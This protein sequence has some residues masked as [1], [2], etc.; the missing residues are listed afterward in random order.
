MR[1]ALLCLLLA[2]A[3]PGA[4]QEL[5]FI[6]FAPSGQA[7]RV[8]FGTD[9]LPGVPAPSASV[10][11]I[12][13]DH[14]GYIWMAFYSSGIARYDGRSM[15]TY[16]TKD[17]LTDPLVRE[18]VEDASHR[19]WVGTEAGLVVSEKPLDAYAPGER[20]K[21]VSK[22][23]NVALTRA[24]MRRNCVVASPDGSVW[25]SAPDGI[26]RYRFEG[27]ALRSD[28]VPDTV[29]AQAL[30]ARRDGTLLAGRVDGRIVAITPDKKQR[31]IGTV[32]SSAT[33]LAET[34]D[35]AIWGGSTD[36]SVWIL[37]NG[38]PR[39]INHE[40]GERVVA[41]HPTHDGKHVWAASLGTGAVRMDR[42]D[43]SDRM[44]ITRAN[45]LLGETLWTI[46]EDR[47]GNL[48]FGQNGGA[49]R[50]RKGYSAFYTWTENTVP[51]LPDARTFAVLPEWRGSMWIATG[52]GLAI[53]HGDTT[54]TLTVGDGLHSNQIYALAPDPEGRLWIATS[55]GINVLSNANH[56]PP[57][58]LAEP[59]R[60]PVIINGEPGVVS[61]LGLETTYAAQRFGDTMCFAGGWGAACWNG[62]RYLLFRAA[63]GLSNTGA[64]SVELD[65][66]GYLWIGSTDR[67]LFHST[68]TLQE[69]F[70]ETPAAGEVT[71][72]IFVAAWT[73]EE[74]APTNGIRSLLHHGDRLWVGTGAGLAALTTSKPFTATNVFAGQPVVGLTPSLDG[75]SIWVSNN[76]GLVQ[77]DARTLA[78]VSRVT[79]AD[80]LADD[81]AWAYGP[82]ATD[83]AGRIYLSTPSGVSVFNP[84]LRERITTPPL[85][86]LRNVLRDD[87]NEIALEYAALSFAD[88][89]RIR[90]RT[91]L[92]GFDKH[93]SAETSDAKTRYTNLPAYLF[94]RKYTF[95]VMARN[96]EG[97]WSQPLAYEFG[98]VPPLGLRWWAVL[99]Y[100]IAIVLALWLSNRWR[101]RQ[102]KRKNR[103]LEDLVMK[104]T[105]EIRA[106]TRE[107]ETL[108]R[109]VEVIN[110]EVVL[111]NVLKTIISQGMKLFPQ[112]QKAVFL[113]FDHETRRTEVINVSGYDPDPFNGSSLT[114]EE[115]MSRYSERAEQLE[116][117]V[118]LIKAA[119]FRHLAGAEK[120]AHLPAPKAMLA[121]ALTLGGRMEGFLIFDNFTDEDAFGRHDLQKLARVREHAV[122][123]IAK[124]R[125]LRELEIRNEQ[126]EEAN[127]AK[128]IFLA[129]MSH[130]LR[131]PMNA[132]IGFSEI[133][134]ERLEERLEPKYIG[135]LR[136]ILQSGQH[137]LSIIND[138]LDLSKVEAG[139]M[140][141][142]PETFG[143]RAGID[144]VCQV[145]K[146]MSTNKGITFD[147][148]VEDGVREIETD[149]AKFKQ[150]LYN[151]L[152]NAVK[153]SKKNGVVTIRARRVG[154]M[155]SVSVTDA[156]IGIAPEHLAVI[157]QEFRQIDTA[158]SRAYGGTGL[159]LSLVKKFVELLRGTVTVTSV[160]D[161]GSTFTFMLPLRFAGAAI[162]SPIVS[163]DGVVIPPGER[164]L[165][166]EDEDA[167]FDT[168]SA[169]LQSAG[170]VPV[171]ARTGQEALERA[172]VMSPRAITLD[173]VLPG[174]E[175]W[176]VLRSLK[177]DAETSD[178]PVVIVS[179]LENREL[180][181][182]FGAEDY[183]VKPV[184]WPR[185][186]RRLSEI[187]GRGAR[188]LLVDDDATVHQMLEQ[189]LVKEGYVL[190]IAT[191]GADAIERAER[192]HPDVIILDL[193]MPGMSG[194]EVAERLRQR[195]S[196]AHIPII[197]LT[198]KDLTAADHDRLR[199]GVSGLVLKGTNAGARLIRAIRSL[200][201]SRAA[202]AAAPPTAV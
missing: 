202:V 11:K 107:L 16:G 197:V 130:E 189:E 124:A 134:L 72:R 79:R 117:G 98:V 50:L 23:G 169:Y 161:E 184:D 13:Q 81:E 105:E 67:G 188:L 147:V 199:H 111:E 90:Y 165:V 57:K 187:T 100:A 116:E 5:P 120:T 191:S 121:M 110:R 31:V 47:E 61:A 113:K 74:G 196:T 44:R 59:R 55:S 148:E 128:S 132:I 137:L 30:L 36:G 38:V 171:R 24:R 152:S 14:Q 201:S 198:A 66:H 119:D 64:T 164:V 167:A 95:E 172:R 159:G 4:A 143:V 126:A 56:L 175:G 93:W 83:A 97:V 158:T 160:L 108:D 138:I 194:F 140:E 1:S 70:N 133:L 144:S 102:L 42:R 12:L 37:E 85:V 125:I 52:A 76:A 94:T 49:S 9:P 192:S 101:M 129:N 22:V 99:I 162:P 179:M 27:N 193:M 154:E 89:S 151:L 73:K 123:A 177:G 142:Y 146:G 153:F 163:P 91:R 178:I 145:M 54:T 8:M 139:K 2:A 32:A 190:E 48:W 176:Q 80:G 77:I 6:H 15:E 45:G 69:I 34:S 135:F 118:Y 19:L 131:T 58:I 155:L 122:S 150:I 136:S 46:Y 106:Q 127:R 166:V 25:V 103:M 78:E 60:T 156:G 75:R 20:L 157:F 186:L 173:L 39:I 185:L 195:E 149:H 26:L 115:A 33:T 181:L 3:L 82:L 7:L 41:I 68:K 88:E 40:L 183:F 200:D 29:P 96:G 62:D 104:R 65:N 87:E 86:R 168:I 17:G 63:S 174:M 114:F 21:F 182:A 141:L 84:A 28:T 53:L 18:I 112:A 180:A 170:Y 109:I 51:P 35:G 92:A 10:Q 71:K 43:P